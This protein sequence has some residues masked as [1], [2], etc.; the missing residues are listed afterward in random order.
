MSRVPAHPLH[1]IIHEPGQLGT[2]AASGRLPLQLGQ[3]VPHLG[4]CLGGVLRS[5]WAIGL[6]TEPVGHLAQDL[7]LL[8]T[9][10]RARLAS[11]GWLVIPFRL[12]WVPIQGFSFL[13]VQASGTSGPAIVAQGCYNFHDLHRRHIGAG[14]AVSKWVAMRRLK[15]AMTLP[16]AYSRRCCGVERIRI[17]EGR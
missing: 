17:Y 10:P 15:N 8:L 13:F 11:G 7:D 14:G 3:I 6:G 2:Q 4:L 16:S 5:V 12:R 9:P 1:Q